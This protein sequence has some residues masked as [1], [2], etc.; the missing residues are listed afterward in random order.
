M[1][2]RYNTKSTNGKEAKRILPKLTTGEQRLTISGKKI[3]KIEKK[4]GC[5]V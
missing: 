2:L 4:S 5:Y 3:N 1:F